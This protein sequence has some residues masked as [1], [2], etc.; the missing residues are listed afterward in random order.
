MNDWAECQLALCNGETPPKMADGAE[1]LKE[2]KLSQQE[3][4]SIL[5]AKKCESGTHDM[6]A[7]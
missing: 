5:V 7:V 6:P 2:I 1:K 4:K 3:N